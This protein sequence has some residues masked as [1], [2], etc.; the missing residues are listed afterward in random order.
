MLLQRSKVLVIDDDPDLLRLISLYLRRSC[1]VITATD[2]AAGLEKATNTKPDVILCDVHMPG[3]DGLTTVK[4]LR[5]VRSLKNVP[6][7]MLTADARTHVAK[8][9]LELG[10]NGYIRKDVLDCED[11]NARIAEAIYCVSV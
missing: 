4:K 11:L 6:I 8:A 3:W 5:E 7:L 9:A 10:A 1:L 2:G